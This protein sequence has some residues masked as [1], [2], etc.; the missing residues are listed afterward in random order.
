MREPRVAVVIPCY[1]VA[2][3]VLD[4]IARV[5]ARVDAIYAVDD[6]CPEQTAIVWPR[7]APIHAVR[8]LRHRRTRAWAA[9]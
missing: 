1:R 3:Q 8:V 7:H 4:V 6:A 5:G 9:R 2:G